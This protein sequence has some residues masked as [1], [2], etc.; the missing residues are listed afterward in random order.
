MEL[1]DYIKPELLILVAVLFCVGAG[2]K[3]SRLSDRHIPA[4]LGVAG[5]AAAVLYICAVTPL[6]TIQD[7]LLAVFVGVTQGILCAGASVYVNQLRK[8]SGKVE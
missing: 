3:R 4:V 6:H 8:Q 1:T 7:I 5:I 2:L